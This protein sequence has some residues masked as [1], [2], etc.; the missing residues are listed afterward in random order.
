MATVTVLPPTLRAKIDAVARHVR[1]LRALRGAGALL[2]VLTLTGGLALLLDFAFD[3]PWPVRAGLLSLWTGLGVSL[4]V[5]GLIVPLCRRLDPETIAA[6]VEE[7][8]PDLG[9]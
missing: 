8:Y 2:L 5:F 6:V 7:K 4:A 1:M 9:E 3:L